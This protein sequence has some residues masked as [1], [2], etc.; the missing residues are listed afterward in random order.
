MTLLDVQ[1]RHEYRILQSHV[2][3]NF[4]LFTMFTIN[5]MDTHICTLKDVHWSST[6]QGCKID[7]N[8][9]VLLDLKI[10]LL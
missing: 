3:G 4:F 10:T 9:L 6:L 7:I 2:H 1:M 5:Y 8:I